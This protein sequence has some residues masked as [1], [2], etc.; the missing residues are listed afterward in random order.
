MKNKSHQVFRRGAQVKFRKTTTPSHLATVECTVVQRN[1][2]SVRVKLT[3]ASGAA[4][5]VGTELTVPPYE[6]EH[7]SGCICKS[8]K[9]RGVQPWKS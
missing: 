4:Y 9:L 6:L 3:Q 8:C 7:E 2:F 5:P 1:Q